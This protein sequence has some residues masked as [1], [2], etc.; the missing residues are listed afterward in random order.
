MT[1][2]T[3]QQPDW[4]GICEN[5]NGPAWPVLRFENKYLEEVSYNVLPF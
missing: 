3:E 4:P 5:F 2:G 1:T